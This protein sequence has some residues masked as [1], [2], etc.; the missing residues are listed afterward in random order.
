MD[1]ACIADFEDRGR[2][3]QAKKRLL[4]DGKSKETDSPLEFLER[5]GIPDN[6]LILA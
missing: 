3:T 5:M 2:D 4:E 6:T 1:L